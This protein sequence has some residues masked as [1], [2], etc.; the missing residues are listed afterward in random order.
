MQKCKT[1]KLRPKHVAVVIKKS[2]VI[3]VYITRIKKKNNIKSQYKRRCGIE[4]YK[5]GDGSHIGLF[6]GPWHSNVVTGCNNHTATRTV[7][8][9]VKIGS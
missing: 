5:K 7:G 8:H 9:K 1:G 2:A 3:V 4:K 6:V